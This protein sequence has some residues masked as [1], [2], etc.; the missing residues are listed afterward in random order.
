MTVDHVPTL[1][2]SYLSG[3][4]QLLGAEADRWVTALPAHIGGALRRWRLKVD[5]P[6]S[7]GVGAVVLPVRLPDGGA[8]ALKVGLMDTESR[9]EA[10]ALRAWEGRGVVLLIDA[11]LELDPHPEAGVGALLLER[12]TPDRSLHDVDEDTAATTLGS[13]LARLA[14]PAGPAADGLPRLEDLARRW[15]DELP[16]GWERL[17]RPCPRRVVDA[18]VATCRELGRDHAPVLV[19]GDLHHGNVLAAQRDEWLAIDPKGMVGEA[20]FDVLPFLRNRWTEL[21]ATTDTRRA[22]ARRL[23]LVVEAAGLDRDRARRWAQARA[24]D[25]LLWCAEHGSSPG[26]SVEVAGA[27]AEWLT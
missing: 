3:I 23:D 18:A 17:G 12:L 25:D 27:L 13:V 15:A 7:H 11:D 21:T 16:A 9:P 2:S 10:V 5:G 19:H 8:A 22:L 20:A 1:P 26:V 4:R 24:V 6:A 14:V